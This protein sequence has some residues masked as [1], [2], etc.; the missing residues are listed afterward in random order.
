MPDSRETHALDIA[1]RL[2]FV[3]RYLYCLQRYVQNIWALTNAIRSMD[4]RV[5]VRGIEFTSNS[6]RHGR[7]AKKPTKCA[8]IA[9]QSRS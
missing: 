1:F 9:T 6:G 7:F 8:Y 2:P 5:V 4:G 3:D